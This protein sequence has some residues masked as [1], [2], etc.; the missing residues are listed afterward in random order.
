MSYHGEPELSVCPPDWTYQWEPGGLRRWYTN[1]EQVHDPVGMTLAK[2]P[3]SGE[4]EP[5]E[6][7]SSR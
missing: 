5:E 2:M 4:M 1:K 7:T 3:K 6:T